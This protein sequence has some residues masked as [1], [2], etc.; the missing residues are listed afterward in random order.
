MLRLRLLISM[1]ALA[2]SAAPV[3][4]E[5]PIVF[6]EDG[7]TF[8]YTSELHGDSVHITGSVVESGESFELVVKQSGRVVGEFGGRSVR[9]SVSKPVRDRLIKGLDNGTSVAVAEAGLR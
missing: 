3:A 5:S 2:L 8:K 9:F 4:A 7:H 6:R 1:S